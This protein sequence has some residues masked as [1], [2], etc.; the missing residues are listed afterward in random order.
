VCRLAADH[1]GVPCGRDSGVLKDLHL[2]VRV[3]RDQRPLRDLTN[4]G[5]GEALVHEHGRCELRVLGDDAVAVAQTGQAGK[6]TRYRVAGTASMVGETPACGSEP[7]STV[8]WPSGLVNIVGLAAGPWA[9]AA[10]GT[11]TDTTDTTHTRVRAHWRHRD[12]DTTA[13][14][15]GSMRQPGAA[16]GTPR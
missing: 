4:G 13:S 10:T 15:C 6:R 5:H 1:D 16:P 3:L 11:P 12:L 2:S 8:N 9:R 7:S 14:G